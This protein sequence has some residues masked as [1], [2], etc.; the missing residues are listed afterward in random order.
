MFELSG[1]GT[2]TIPPISSA[3]KP[4]GVSSYRRMNSAWPSRW[5]STSSGMAGRAVVVRRCSWA[6]PPGRGPFGPVRSDVFDRPRRSPTGDGRAAFAAGGGA[7]VDGLAAAGTDPQAG[8]ELDLRR[9]GCRRSLPGRNPGT[10]GT[11]A[12]VAS[13]SYAGRAGRQCARSIPPTGEVGL[14]HLVGPRL[15]IADWTAH[16]ATPDQRESAPGPPARNR[17][18][19]P[20]PDGSTPALSADARTGRGTG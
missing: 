5:P 2:W 1:L 8:L 3:V 11:A 15:R 19:C 10:A 13:A 12:G 17:G 16:R 4:G 20:P 6:L 14:V 9:R 18:T 7:Q